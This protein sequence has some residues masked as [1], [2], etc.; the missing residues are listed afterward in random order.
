[1]AQYGLG[2]CQLVIGVGNENGIHRGCPQ[3]GIIR[4]SRNDPNVRLAPKQGADAQ[5]KQRKSA[6][7]DRNHLACGADRIRKFQGKVP[8]SRTEI[9]DNASIFEVKSSNDVGW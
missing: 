2:S 7:V 8:R 6:K 4:I 3:V 1:M 9:D 5:E